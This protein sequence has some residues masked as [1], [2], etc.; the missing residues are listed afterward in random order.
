MDDLSAELRP[1][2]DALSNALFGM[3]E[4]FVRNSGAFL[5][6]GAVLAGRSRRRP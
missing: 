1:D 4:V 6:H 3:S 2:I 5:P